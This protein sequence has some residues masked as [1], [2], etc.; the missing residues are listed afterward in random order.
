MEKGAKWIDDQTRN[1]TKV[2]GDLEEDVLASLWEIGSGNVKQIHEHL[3]KVRKSAVTTVA[4]V[5][6]R[7]HQKGLV[8]RELHKA[9]GIRYEYKPAMSR[10]QFE[11][12]VVGNIFDRLFETFG[13]SAV[14]YLIQNIEIEDPETIE[15]LR[16]TLERLVK[17]TD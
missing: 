13:E 6:D 4:T 5:L 1:R 8:E 11:T 16:K 7:L 9:G 2:L 10:K 15:E 3:N 14:N 17:E 12:A